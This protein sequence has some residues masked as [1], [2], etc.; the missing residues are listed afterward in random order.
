MEPRPPWRM[1]G[2]RE[3]SDSHARENNA[4]EVIWSSLVM[5]LAHSPCGRPVRPGRTPFSV[6]PVAVRVRCGT[7]RTVQSVIAPRASNRIP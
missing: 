1:R 6:S 4:P 3:G 2:H 5:L 7:I